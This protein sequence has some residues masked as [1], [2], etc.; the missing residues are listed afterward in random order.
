[1]KSQD[2]EL[3]ELRKLVEAWEAIERK[4][5]KHYSIANINKRLS[6]VKWKH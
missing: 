3:K 5:T 1:M 6:V 4:W 2:E